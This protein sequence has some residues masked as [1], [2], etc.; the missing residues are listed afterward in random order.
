[1]VIGSVIKDYYKLGHYKI[2]LDPNLDLW[3]YLE[4]HINTEL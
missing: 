4:Q 1:M 2:L 3:S